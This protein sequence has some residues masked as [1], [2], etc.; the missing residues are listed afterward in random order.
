MP[1]YTVS[2]AKFKSQKCTAV[3]FYGAPPYRPCSRRGDVQL[4]ATSR[5]TPSRALGHSGLALIIPKLYSMAPPMSYLLLIYL[6]MLPR[7]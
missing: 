7:A 2:D 3:K 5:S 4:G 1:L 6:L